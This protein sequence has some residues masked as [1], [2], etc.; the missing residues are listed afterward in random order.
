MRRANIVRVQTFWR[1]CDVWYFI[2]VLLYYSGVFFAGVPT[3]DDR[4]DGEWRGRRRRRAV[5]H[6]RTTRWVDSDL[7]AFWPFAR[8]LS[9]VPCRTASLPLRCYPSPVP[10]TLSLLRS[11]PPL[12][13]RCAARRR[14]QYGPPKKQR[15]GHPGPFQ[16]KGAEGSFEWSGY[17]P[18]H[19]SFICIPSSTLPDPSSSRVLIHFTLAV[20]LW[21]FS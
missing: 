21:I 6:K 8:R 19:I 5:R 7:V 2:I 1:V 18:V 14:G 4:R 9:W 12:S 11:P 3:N 17:V 13:L 15:E 16:P 20:V 10:L